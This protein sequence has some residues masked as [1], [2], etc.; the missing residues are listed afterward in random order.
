METIF[1]RLGDPV[2]V[3]ERER[4]PL[5]RGLRAG[6]QVTVLGFL[7]AQ[8]M[9]GAGGRRFVVSMSNI[10]CS[11]VR[12]GDEGGEGVEMGDGEGMGRG[13]ALGD[14]GRRRRFN[15]YR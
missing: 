2:W 4:Y 11:E 6:Q 15:T 10:R 1:C 8:R 7:P 12:S 3:C 5:P 9:V 14:R 13:W